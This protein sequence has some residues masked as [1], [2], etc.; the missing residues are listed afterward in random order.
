MLV[1]CNFSFLCSQ[2]RYNF[3]LQYLGKSYHKI[4]FLCPVLH[5]SK[6]SVKSEAIL[7]SCTHR[8]LELCDPEIW[9][10][11]TENRKGFRVCKP[12]KLFWAKPQLGQK[13]P[14]HVQKWTA[15]QSRSLM[16]WRN[17]STGT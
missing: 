13:E 15:G 3:I 17:G 9:P 12:S 10:F 7:A 2:I 5:L 1:K 16:I 14:I 8:H 4:T 6:T 11:G